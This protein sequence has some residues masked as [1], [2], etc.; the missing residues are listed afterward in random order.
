[1]RRGRG[2]LVIGVDGKGVERE[3]SEW[4]KKIWDIR[5]CGKAMLVI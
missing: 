4:K 2:A 3:R 5:V 1:M